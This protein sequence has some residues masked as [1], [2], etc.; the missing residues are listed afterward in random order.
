MIGAAGKSA[1]L[2]IAQADGEQR[3]LLELDLEVSLGPAL[4]LGQQLGQPDHLQGALA[5]IMRLFGVEQQDPVGHF[6]IGHHNGD[7]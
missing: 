2:L 6:D 4:G 7:H 1:V 3:R 5:E